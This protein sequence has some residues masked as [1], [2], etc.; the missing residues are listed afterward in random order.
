MLGFLGA[1]ASSALDAP[2]LSVIFAG[3]SSDIESAASEVKGT[4][5]DVDMFAGTF[6]HEVD[7]SGKFCYDNL[8]SFVLTHFREEGTSRRTVPDRSASNGRL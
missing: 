4:E 7:V 3:D 2:S 5:K 1:S 8:V 6:R